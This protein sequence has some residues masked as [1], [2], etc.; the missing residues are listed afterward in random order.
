MI[1]IDKTKI[2]NAT[3]RHVETT[4][5]LKGISNYSDRFSFCFK[6]TFRDDYFFPLLIKEAT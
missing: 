6:C 4:E 2:N 5:I 3:K 1:G